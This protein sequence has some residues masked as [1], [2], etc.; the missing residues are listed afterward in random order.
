MSGEYPGD[1]RHDEGPSTLSAPRMPVSPS[2][3]SRRAT[4]C[5]VSGF[6]ALIAAFYPFFG[7]FVAAPLGVIA[8]L[9]GAHGR[10][11]GAYR[12]KCMVG[13]ALGV[14]ALVVSLAWNAFLLFGPTVPGLNS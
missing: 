4:N 11:S 5:V 8:I 6:V 3:E 14:L 12:R 10:S 13:L 9:L 7:V 1:A 2:R